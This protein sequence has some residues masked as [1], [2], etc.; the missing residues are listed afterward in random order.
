MKKRLI[1][2]LSALVF[3]LCACSSVSEDN[4]TDATE[5]KD[6]IETRPTIND[7]YTNEVTEIRTNVKERTNRPTEFE[8]GSSYDDLI[9]Y[10]TSSDADKALAVLPS[11]KIAVSE[12]I[13]AKRV[14]PT[15]N[16][17]GSWCVVET[18]VDTLPFDKAVRVKV[19]ELPKSP[20]SFQ[21][22]CGTSLLSENLENEH[23]ILIEV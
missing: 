17:T 15:E 2:L 18:D 22:S 12:D 13:L 3:V 23:V 14:S 4:V 21:L 19:N 5:G 20:Y 16:K 1:S 9:F 6:A 11:P 8:R 10:D 7:S